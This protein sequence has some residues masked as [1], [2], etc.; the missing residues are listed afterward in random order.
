MKAEIFTEQ[1]HHK[2]VVGIFGQLLVMKRRLSATSLLLAAALYGCEME[3]KNHTTQIQ[4]MEDTL[5]KSFPTV[6]RVGI[7]VRNDFSKEVNVTLGDMELHTAPEEKRLEV[8]EKTTALVRHIFSGD[9]IEPGNVIF[10]KE[11]N[12]LVVDEA[13]VKRYKMNLPKQ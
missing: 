8:V 11:E 13:T 1:A 6:N 3:P 12:T 2:I 4:Q 5:F 9:N 10:V 7:E